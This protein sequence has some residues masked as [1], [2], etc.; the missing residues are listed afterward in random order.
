MLAYRFKM[1]NGHLM[2]CDSCV[3]YK[4]YQF[5]EHFVTCMNNIYIH[6]IYPDILFNYIFKISYFAKIFI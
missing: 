3:E 6:Q 4:F 5:Y 1:K 2:F